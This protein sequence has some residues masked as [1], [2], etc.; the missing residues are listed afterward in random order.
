MLSEVSIDDHK[1]TNWKPEVFCHLF[2]RPVF[3]P[4]PPKPEALSLLRDHFE[5]FNCMLPLPCEGGEIKAP[6]FNFTEDIQYGFPTDRAFG[7][8]E[9]VLI[10]EAG[11]IWVPD[12]VL[13]LRAGGGDD[14]AFHIVR[15]D[16]LYPI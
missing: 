15:L 2:Q 3:R 6:Q 13:S 9:L 10:K 1:W 16:H 4:L 7:T 12:Y 11:S 5:N 8:V 14:D